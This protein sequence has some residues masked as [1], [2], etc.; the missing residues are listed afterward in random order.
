MVNGAGL[1]P[2]AAGLKVRC[3][4]ELKSTN[5]GV[6]GPDETQGTLKGTLDDAKTSHIDAIREVLAGLSKEDLIA[7]PADTLTKTTEG[8]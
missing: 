8:Q 5:T 2:T 6:S 1:E 3:G 4:S 7:L